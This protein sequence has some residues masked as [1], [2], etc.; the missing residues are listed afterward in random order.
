[1]PLPSRNEHGYPPCLL[2]APIDSRRK[3]RSGVSQI[4]SN[5]QHFRWIPHPPPGLPLEG[6]GTRK[7]CPRRG[8]SGQWS[9]G[10]SQSSKI[11]HILCKRETHDGSRFGGLK[12]LTFSSMAF[13]AAEVRVT[14][15]SAAIP[16]ATGRQS[17]Q[18]YRIFFPFI[19]TPLAP[20]F[21]DSHSTPNEP[22]VLATRGRSG[23]KR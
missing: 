8:R 6:G 11:P 7:F 22:P 15:C 21:P 13:T 14:R 10:S 19:G 3:R 16:N 2:C 5:I 12:R 4:R 17:R 20:T 1:M 9:L 23:E 18:H